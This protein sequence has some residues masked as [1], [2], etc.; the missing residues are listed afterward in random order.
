M[1]DFDE[2]MKTHEMGWVLWLVEQIERGDGVVPP[3]HATLEERW[4]YLQHNVPSNKQHAV[5]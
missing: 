2:Y 3:L 4:A 5:A 1:P